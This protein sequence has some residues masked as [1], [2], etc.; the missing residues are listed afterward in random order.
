MLVFLNDQKPY[1]RLVKLDSTTLE[2]LSDAVFEV[3]FF[4]KYLTTYCFG[5]TITRKENL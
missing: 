5:S 4:K 1:I 3:N 2:P